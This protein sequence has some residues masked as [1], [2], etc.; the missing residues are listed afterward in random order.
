MKTIEGIPYYFNFDGLEFVRMIGELKVYASIE[1]KNIYIFYNVDS[2]DKYDRS[3]GF[4]TDNTNL[5]LYLL[6]KTITLRELV[7]K[8]ENW[9]LFLTDT[10]KES[11]MEF[12]KIVSKKDIPKEYLPIKDSLFR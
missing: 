8:S 10:D 9:F 6:A 1:D 7:E 4:K 11:G 2:D 12:C 3:L 5:N